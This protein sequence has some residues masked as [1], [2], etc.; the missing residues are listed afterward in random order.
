VRQIDILDPDCR[1][2]IESVDRQ[3]ARGMVRDERAVWVEGRPA[4]RLLR[5]V[6]EWRGRSA[7]PGP[8]LIEGNAA[9]RLDAQAV[10]AAWGNR[11]D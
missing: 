1:M 10:T 7:D 4:I 2:V 5:T 9:G 8:G 3:I 6:Y 11:H